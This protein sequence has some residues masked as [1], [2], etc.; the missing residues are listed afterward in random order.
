MHFVLSNIISSAIAYKFGGRFMFNFLSSVISGGLIF[1]SIAGDK[2]KDEL[3]KKSEYQKEI[4]PVA[5]GIVLGAAYSIYMDA[6]PALYRSLG[7]PFQRLNASLYRSGALFSIVLGMML[8]P[9]LIDKLKDIT[10][11]LKEGVKNSTNKNANALTK[12]LNGLED[13][14]KRIASFIGM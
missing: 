6:Y 14:Q 11:P 5:I 13:N 8:L 10:G 7:M 2:I 12:I 1:D 3:Y 4:A 9:I